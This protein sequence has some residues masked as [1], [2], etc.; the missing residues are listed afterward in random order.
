MTTGYYAAPDETARA[1]EDGWLHTGDVGALDAE[2]RLTIRGRKK[3][4]IVTPEGLERLSGGCGTRARGAAR[5]QGGG[6]RGRVS[7]GRGR[8]RTVHAVLVVQPDA[9]VE[10]IV[11]AANARLEDYQRIR[12]VSTWPGAE[13]PRTEGTRKLKRRELQRWVAQGST[14]AGAPVH[15]KSVED[16]LRRSSARGTFPETTLEA[17][18]LSSLERV[19]LMMALEEAFET[20]IDEAAFPVCAP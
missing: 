7:D 14:G 20:T 12:G 10:A 11:A 13:L 15:A 2:G 1:F 6:C 9:S 16:V 4:M 19:E 8:R 18:G 5:R 17:L 3:E